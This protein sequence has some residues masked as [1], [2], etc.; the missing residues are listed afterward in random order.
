MCTPAGSPACARRRRGVTGWTHRRRASLTAALPLRIANEHGWEI[1]S[2][3]GFAASWNGG[4]LPE[5][6]SITVD[7]GTRPQDRP[8]ALFGQATLTFHIPALFRTP[9][10]WNLW[11]SGVAQPG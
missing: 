9:P 6:V 7:P 11:L 4:P 1:L 10:G 8:V 5:D 3:C 2:P